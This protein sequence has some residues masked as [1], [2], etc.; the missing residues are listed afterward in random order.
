MNRGVPD[1]LARSSLIKRVEEH[2][3]NIRVLKRESRGHDRTCSTLATVRAF[4]RWRK[5]N[6]GEVS[7]SGA[8]VSN[9][10]HEL[11]DWVLDYLAELMACSIYRIPERWLGN[12]RWRGGGRRMK[13]ALSQE[14]GCF[15]RGEFI[16]DHRICVTRAIATW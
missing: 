5:T 10:R 11:M 14:I 8:Q 13:R 1:D 7:N 6:L 2:Q 15:H 12:L 3:E 9:W 16:G 4:S